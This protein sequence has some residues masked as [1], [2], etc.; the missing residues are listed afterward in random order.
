M[1]TVTCTITFEDGAT[2]TAKAAAKAE[3]ERVI[4][5]FS[6]DLARIRALPEKGTLGFLEWYLTG[7]AAN[8]GGEL[9]TVAEGAYQDGQG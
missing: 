7:C 6:G 2:V 4:F 1:R 9:K 5:Q 3:N 8:F